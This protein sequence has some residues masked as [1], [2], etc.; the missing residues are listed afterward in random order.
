[1]EKSE[2]FTRR[3]FARIKSVLRRAKWVLLWERLWP[4]LFSFLIVAMVYA[5]FSWLGLWAFLPVWSKAIALG[6]FALFCFV[7]VLRT[8]RVEPPKLDEVVARVEKVS[9]VSHRPLTAS[10]DVPIGENA[11]PQ[12]PQNVLWSAHQQRITEGLAKLKAG[13]PQPFLQKRDPYALRALLILVTFIGFNVAGS[14]RWLRLKDGFDFSNTR[15]GVVARLDAWVTPPRYTGKPPIFLT[16]EKLDAEA[17]PLVVPA[18]SLLTIRSVNADA[19]VVTFTR[20]EAEPVAIAATTKDEAEGAVANSNQTDYELTLDESGT[21]MV[22]KVRGANSWTFDVMPDTPPIIAFVDTPEAQRSGALQVIAAIKDDYGVARAEA[23]I[24]PLGH[25]SKDDVRPLYDAPQFPLALRRGRTKDGASKTLR[26]LVEHPWAGAEI[27]MSLRAFDEAG[28]EG[29]SEALTFLLPSRRF[30]NAFSRAIIEQRRALA[31]DGNY[32]DELVDVIDSLTVRPEQ[33]ADDY[34]AYIALAGVRRGLLDARNDDALRKIVDDL[35]DLAVGIEDGDLSDAERRLREALE[36]LREGIRDGASEEELARLMNEARQALNEFMQAL[37]EQAQNNND[38]AQNQQP[39]DP[40]Q[41]LSPQDL[42]EM[43]DRIQEL[44]QTGSQ[45]AAE[46]LLSQLQQMMENL[47]AQ[48]QQGQQGENPTREA[49]NELGEMIREQ[50]QLLDQ[51]YR[52]QREGSGEQQGEQGQEGQQGEQGQEGQQGEQ[53]QEGQQG[54]QGQEG[55]Q[56]QQGQGQAQSGRSGQT[57]RPGQGGEGGQGGKS[58]QQGQ[59]DLA[60]RLRRFMDGLSEGA[61]D[62]SGQLGEAQRS[63]RG[64]ADELGDGDLG[65][66]GEEQTRALNELRAG[67]QALAEQLAGEGQGEGSRNEARG[68]QGRDPLGRRDGNRNA[69]FGNNVEVPDEI[70]IQRAREILDAIRRRLG[71]TLRPQI[72]LDYL[73][74]LLRSE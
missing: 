37:A 25:G 35:W 23:M 71:E 57:G 52:Q 34:A 21:V 4:A 65:A 20:D 63:M 45:D 29:R 70:D 12:S 67:A 27:N 30:L 26:S 31:L 74:R 66:A 40:S 59:S 73:E 72:E 49:L 19:T 10:L 33:Y 41:A 39:S 13:W 58:V 48:N 1:M 54:E 17:G 36:A 28:Q 64:A 47:Q 32:A 68:Q 62:P 5:S 15:A 61:N 50:Q 43:L 6:L 7:V 14:E 11:D 46:Q 2:L 22:D 38:T 53:G 3:G 60:D 9:G 42:Q 16:K 51:T 18:G 44:A 24:E 56:G 8:F 55:Q 69:D